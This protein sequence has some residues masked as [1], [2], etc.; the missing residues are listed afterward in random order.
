[1]SI[2]I[3]VILACLPFGTLAATTEDT[4]LT[5][6]EAMT[7]MS[8]RQLFDHASGYS[9]SDP[10]S[11]LI[12]YDILANRYSSS[13]S[14]E[15]ARLC[16]RGLLAS[17]E[18]FYNHF[19]YSRQMEALLRCRKICEDND[20]K[21]ILSDAYRNIGNI[22]S[23]HEDFDHAIGF[24]KEAL[25]SSKAVY[26]SRRSHKTLSNLVGAHIFINDLESA[27]SYYSQM[28]RN[29]VDDPLY[30]YDILVDG[31]LLEFNKGNDE[32]ALQMLSEASA[33]I[34]SNGLGSAQKGT[35]NSWLASIH[36]AAGRPDSALMFL[37]ANEV[38]ARE[39]GMDD[40]LAET[41]RSLHGLYKESGQSEKATGYL[42]EYLV[43]ADKVFNQKAFNT[44]KN[45]QFQWELDKSDHK[46]KDLTE[47]RLRQQ[48][49]IE[50]QRTII[51]IVI[52]G[53]L[54]LAF[55][56]VI[57]YRQK[58]RISKA[59][60][61]MYERNRAML[62]KERH[63]QSL[64][65]ELQ[66]QSDHRDLPAPC[67]ASTPAV[68]EQRV[69]EVAGDIPQELKYKLL[70]DIETAMERPELFCDPDFTINTLAEEIGSNSTYVSKVINKTFGMNFRSF[71]S[72]HRI[73]E[74]MIRMSDEAGY[75]HYTINAIAES[76]GFRSQSAFIAAFTRF[77]GMKPSTYQQIARKKMS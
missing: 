73:K 8:S 49:H 32:R 36:T 4:D 24:Y 13:M 2:F 52:S 40:L 61:D 23:V 75:A 66:E 1:M 12:Y 54:V 59:Y 47:E 60:S 19:N 42:E 15:E 68:A 14:R 33:Y 63:L 71:L 37:R 64:I 21:D 7:L 62:E 41:L 46:I 18:I 26:D 3:A 25:A 29:R 31:A 51:R 38:L 69:D 5:R 28:A 11:A 74:S 20:F 56:L 72:E 57:I 39:S 30:R 58:E 76:V 45:T 43:L 9:E 55:L 77:T 10:D 44:L 50:Q 27:D 35:V 16:A 17:A 22:Y 70:R 48:L 53:L 65:R 6:Y 34:D 67:E